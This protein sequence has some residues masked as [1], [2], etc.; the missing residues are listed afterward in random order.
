MLCGDG[1]YFSR[2]LVEENNNMILTCLAL[3]LVLL[4]PF[5]LRK[6]KVLNLIQMLYLSIIYLC[7]LRTF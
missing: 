3:P 6:L 2:A 7:F 4:I 5:I 1:V